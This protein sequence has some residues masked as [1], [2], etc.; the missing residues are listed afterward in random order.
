MEFLRK[1]LEDL[2]K[3]IPDISGHACLARKIAAVTLTL[4]KNGGRFDAKYLKPQAA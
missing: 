3:L 1:P 4:W 2:R